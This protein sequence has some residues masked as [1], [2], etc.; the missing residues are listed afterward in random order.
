MVATSLS[1]K[2]TV[3]VVDDSMFNR[4]LLA[5]MMADEFN[6]IEAEN[7]KQA[8]AAISKLGLGISL[9][10]LDY[11]M[12]EMDG[13]AVLSVMQRRGWIKDI[14]VVMVSA[15]SDPAYIERAY[16]LGATDFL[17]R[18]F[19]INIVRHRVRNTIMLYSKQRV[20][21]GMV[22]DEINE[23]ERDVNLMVSILS[24][25]VEFRNGESGMHVLR[26]RALTEILLTCLAEKTDA[27]DLASADISTIS[28]A[29]SLHDIG[30]IAIAEEILNKPGRLTD[31]EFRIM[32]T[33]SAVGAEM[34]EKLPTG[35]NEPLVKTAYAICRWHH[36]RYDGRGYP[37][38]LV[39]DDIPISAQVVALADVYDALTSERV[40]KPAFSHEKAM[41]MIIGGECGAFNPLLI[42]VLRDNADSIHGQMESLSSDGRGNYGTK[43]VMEALAD[44]DEKGTTSRTISLLDYE[45]MKYN[46]YA[47]MSNEVQYELSQDPPMLVMS[48]YGRI[49]LGLPEVIPDPENSET[50]IRVFGREGVTEFLHRMMDTSPDDPI[51][52]F[53]MCGVANG[54]TRWYNVV[55]RALWSDDDKPVYMGALGKLTDVHDQRSLLMDLQ[56]RAWHDSLTAL[57]NHA[58]ARKVA[59]ERMEANPDC[60]FIMLI[61]DLDHFKEANDTYGHEFGDRVLRYFADRLSASV[62]EDDLVARIGGDEFLVFMMCDQETDRRHLARRIH[63]AIR[64]EFEGF[65]VSSSMGVACADVVGKD[66][67]E[68]F[69]CAD[70]ALYR[71]KRLGGGS[72]SFCEDETGP[73]CEVSSLSPIDKPERSYTGRERRQSAGVAKR[74]G[75]DKS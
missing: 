7:G 66:Y 23:R 25:I 75:N 21:A 6:V 32:K 62:R 4:A 48:D 18:P 61:V 55:S 67:D 28:M 35:Q 52:R 26:V 72:C 49:N 11:V 73:V 70:R 33:H 56:F 47:E 12:P 8:I 34:L 46:F 68:M 17:T 41:S 60:L 36:E 44:V 39:G 5:D 57:A 22:A 24:H 16:E 19:D 51:V 71:V 64:S 14:P 43:R 40:Y 3:L 20:L 63:S 74:R 45:R 50:L 1:K 42:D 38:G 13:F 2:K 59:T 37:D 30:K 69:R 10:L 58:Y 31:E 53:D 27:Y 65:P 15:E 9:V 54:E 29:S